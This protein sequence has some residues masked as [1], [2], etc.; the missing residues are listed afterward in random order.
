MPAMAMIDQQSF[1]PV[2]INQTAVIGL[3]V[4]VV[5][6]ALYYVSLSSKSRI[7]YKLIILSSSQQQ[8]TSLSSKASPKFLELSP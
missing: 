4:A 2:S 7:F 5:L 6:Y 1:L 3:A 8:L